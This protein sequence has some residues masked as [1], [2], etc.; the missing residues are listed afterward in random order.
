MAATYEPIATTTLSSA[1]SSITFSSIPGTYTDLRLVVCGADASAVATYY[2]L[3]FN[4]DTAANYSRTRISGNGTAASSNRTTG[5]TN[6]SIGVT[7]A[8]STNLSMVTADIFSYAGS[9]YKTTLSQSSGD[10]NGS[11]Q[12]N[13]FVSL[14]R[15]TSAINAIKVF[16]DSGNNLIAGTT[17]TLYGIL[18]A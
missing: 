10:N 4:S 5:D 16:L 6:L 8:S 13:C 14:W 7:A 18:K 1:A 2:A 12:V 9:T 11:G 17:A 3:Q 15:S